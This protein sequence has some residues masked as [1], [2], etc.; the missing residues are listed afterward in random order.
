M[1]YCYQEWDALALAA[2]RDEV[3]IKPGAIQLLGLPI[4]NN[5]NKARAFQNF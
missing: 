5:C 4:S 2:Y 3:P 1:G